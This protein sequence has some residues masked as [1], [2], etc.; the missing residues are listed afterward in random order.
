VPFVFTNSA[1]PTSCQLDTDYFKGAA[2]IALLGSAGQTLTTAALTAI[3]WGYVSWDPFRMWS[4][5]NPTRITPPTGAQLVR[6][7]AKTHW[8][9]NPTP[10]FVNI[11]QDGNT[12]QGSMA[13]SAQPNQSETTVESGPVHVNPGDYFEMYVTQSS[14]SNATLIQSDETELTCEVLR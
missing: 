6:I 1:T 12:Y 14:G 10:V 3:S 11:E 4:S 9:S 7:V 2:C 13:L 5:A 8:S